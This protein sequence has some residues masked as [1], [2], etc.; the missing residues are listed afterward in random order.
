MGIF[1]Y[2]CPLGT[3]LKWAIVLHCSLRVAPA[4]QAEPCVT[5]AQASLP[6]SVGHVEVPMRPQA[7]AGREGTVAGVE[8]WVFR[9]LCH[10]TYAIRDCLSPILYPP[11]PSGDRVLPSVFNSMTWWL[12]SHLVHEKKLLW[13]SRQGSMISIQ[14]LLRPI[15]DQKSFHKRRK[16]IAEVSRVLLPNP[17]ASVT[18]LWV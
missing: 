14:S 18:Y 7:R 10:V 3:S 9:P 13:H 15:A 11:F 1:L 2:H 8:P 6:L 4:F 5:Q 12:R 16:V 17:K